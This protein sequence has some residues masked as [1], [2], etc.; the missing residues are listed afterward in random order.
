MVLPDCINWLWLEHVSPPS[1]CFLQVLFFFPLDPGKPKTRAWLPTSGPHP[2]AHSALVY[3]SPCAEETWSQKSHPSPDPQ[4]CLGLQGA[5][6][7]EQWRVGESSPRQLPPRPPAHLSSP[8]GLILL[9]TTKLTIRILKP[10]NLRIRIAP[11]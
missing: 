10:K 6:I 3:P 9:F 11:Q 8:P 2:Q 5:S 4:R 1:P 7:R